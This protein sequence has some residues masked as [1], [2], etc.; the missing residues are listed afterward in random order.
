MP[1]LT[2]ENP[3]EMTGRLMKSLILQMQI[4]SSSSHE[5][6]SLEL[7]RVPAQPSLTA[8]FAWKP[9]LQLHAKM[10]LGLY[11]PSKQQKNKKC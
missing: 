2:C 4:N 5:W 3:R 9:Q 1:L 11:I 10:I 7:G 8:P 6:S